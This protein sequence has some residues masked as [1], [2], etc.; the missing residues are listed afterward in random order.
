MIFSSLNHALRVPLAAEVWSASRT[1]FAILG[2]LA[3]KRKKAGDENAALLLKT[4]VAHDAVSKKD[5]Q[6]W[7]KQASS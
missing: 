5:I 6:E 1:Q 4:L 2:Q 3:W 7:K